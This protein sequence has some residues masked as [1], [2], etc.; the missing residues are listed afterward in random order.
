MEG[1][2]GIGEM[3]GFSWKKSLEILLPFRFK[4][5]F[6]VLII[7]WLAGAGI[8]GCSL[9]FNLPKFPKPTKKISIPNVEP[10]KIQLPPPPQSLT[11]EAP[12]APLS[13]P[14][15]E[16]EAPP[17]GEG[18]ALSPGMADPK[19][20]VE[21][22]AA[23]KKSERSRIN[24]AMV[25]PLAIGLGAA[26]FVLM[27]CLMWLSSRFNFILLDA[28]VARDVMIG[29]SFKVHQESG[30]S[31]FKWS[32]AFIGISVAVVLALGLCLIPVFKM[33]KWSPALA[34][35][36]GVLVALLL[37]SVL[38]TVLLVT[39]SV[40]DFV[41][42]VMYKEKGRI[43]ACIGKFLR[44]NGFSKKEILKYLLVILGFG[45]VAGIVQAIVS[46]VVAIVGIIAGG[47]MAIPGIIL[48]KAVPLLKLPILMIG[49]VLILA[50]VVT[51]MVVI[52]MVMLPVAVFFRV[53][54]LAFLTRLYPDCDLLNFEKK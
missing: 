19:R 32:L 54:A 8:Q 4:R 38:L 44:S 46:I 42:P 5:W 43:R 16:L 14:A 22:Q 49:V 39:I 21:L 51:V 36:L 31:Y 45:I 52:G 20:I 15:G 53:F 1:Q 25:A 17:E 2:T 29:K 27:L 30:N 48:L 23:M 28:I 9:N 11:E 24:P 41:V 33:A 34:V 50:L 35:L 47:I 40:R 12:V 6:K 7:V 37:L 18:Q 26:G 10:I 13:T 3:I